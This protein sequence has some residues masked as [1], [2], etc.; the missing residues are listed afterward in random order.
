M[1]S[2]RTV[3]AGEHCV[4]GRSGPNRTRAAQS[5]ALVYIAGSGAR[6]GNYLRPDSVG[7]C[8]LTVP[9]K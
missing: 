8:L 2:G 3:R 9:K 1:P 5:A 6:F 4:D 7:I